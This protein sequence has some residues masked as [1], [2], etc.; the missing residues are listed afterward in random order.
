MLK[1]GD[2]AKAFKNVAIERDAG[3][4]QLTFHSDGGSLIWGKEPGTHSD[5]ANALS[6]VA[7]DPEN[8]VII[9]TG[10][11]DMF[12]GPAASP[13]TFPRGGPERW[14]F[15]RANAVRILNSLLDMPGPVI[16]CINGPAYRHSQIPLLGDVV[17]A[18]DHAIIQDSAHFPN[19]IVPGD[20]VQLVFPLLMGWT[21]ARYFLLTG[22]TLTAAELHDLG[23]VNEV[24]PLQDLL[25]RAWELARTMA[26]QDPLVLRYTR[27]AMVAGLRDLIQRHLGHG[28][29]LEGLAG[30]SV[31]ASNKD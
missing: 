2:Y 26:T 14:E 23:L 4:V 10:A 31:A 16:G 28:L 27:T 7:Q 13:A 9:I 20:G 8:R 12:C 6:A 19:R 24:L 15:L 22:Q 25:P 21:R 1:F 3:I 5:M 11:G 17:L 29:A 18:A 30:L